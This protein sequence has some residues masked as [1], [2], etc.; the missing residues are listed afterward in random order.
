MKTD[1]EIAREIRLA[2]IQDITQDLGI[3]SS[4]VEPYG[5]H[6]AKIGLECLRP[7][8]IAKNNLILVTAIT[9]QQVGGR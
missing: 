3:D 5:H 4:Q 2:P 9:P 8:K 6:I 1:I 7:E